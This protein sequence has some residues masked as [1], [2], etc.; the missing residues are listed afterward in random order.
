M[1]DRNVFVADQYGAGCRLWMLRFG[2]FNR[3]NVA[4]RQRNAMSH[5]S[6]RSIEACTF[7]ILNWA[8]PSEM[9]DWTPLAIAGDEGWRKTVPNGA[10]RSD[11]LERPTR[12]CCLLTCDA[13]L[14]SL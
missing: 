10:I 6:N 13:G 14:R 4:C 3:S 2:S 11:R 12:L 7:P 5:L 1:A 8:M 9:S